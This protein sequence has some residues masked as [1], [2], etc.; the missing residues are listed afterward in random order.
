[1]KMHHRNF[2]EEILSSNW[3]INSIK[4]EREC[5][6]NIPFQVLIDHIDR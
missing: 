2:K 5:S 1:M 6:D 3:P 4:R